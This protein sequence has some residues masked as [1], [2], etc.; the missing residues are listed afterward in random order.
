MGG[1]L[2]VVDRGA[3]RMRQDGLV[4]CEAEIVWEGLEAALAVRAQVL[5]LRE[6]V[7][8]ASMLAKVNCSIKCM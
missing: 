6:K 3:M 1:A 5:A 2:S 7:R 4:R 8:R